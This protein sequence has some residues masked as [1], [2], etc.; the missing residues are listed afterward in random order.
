MKESSF[1]VDNVITRQR[2]SIIYWNIKNQI[3]KESM[4]ETNVIT[5][6]LGRG[7]YLNI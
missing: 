5:R 2:I 3:M 1:L 6:Q 4:K 7:I